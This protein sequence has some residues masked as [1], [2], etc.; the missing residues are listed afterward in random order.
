VAYGKRLVW[1][2]PQE[3]GEH[4]WEILRAL[5]T[6]APGESSLGELLEHTRQSIRQRASLILI[7]PN[8][9]GDWLEALLPLTW[10]GSVP[11]VL[12]L[13]PSTFGNHADNRALLASLAESGIQGYSISREL[14]ERPEAVPGK[15]GRWEWR[16]SPTGR[17]VAVRRPHDLDWKVLS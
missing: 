3:G 17:A 10:R 7:T 16:V 11:T 8:V 4:R 1:I 2:P 13:D 14:L 9:H 15:A 12:L 5:A 6:V